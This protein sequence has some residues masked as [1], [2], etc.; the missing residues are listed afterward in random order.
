[1]SKPKIILPIGVLYSP[2]M[3]Y[4]EFARICEV[5]ISTVITWGKEEIIPTI[6]L[7]S[8]RLVNIAKLSSDALG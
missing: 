2:V 7:K 4:S 6:K 3:S 8:K 1:M 5:E